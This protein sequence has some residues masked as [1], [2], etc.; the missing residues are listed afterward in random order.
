VWWHNQTFEPAEV[1]VAD[2]RVDSVVLVVAVVSVLSVVSVVSVVLVVAVV[3]AVPVV[4]VVVV[5]ATLEVV[6]VVI[7]V[8]TL[9]VSSLSLPAPKA[10]ADHTPRASNTTPAISVSARLYLYPYR[11]AIASILN[12]SVLVG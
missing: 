5:L 6:S 8:G 3:P 1:G 11:R 12:L 2:V 7:V 9:E 4:S 10:T